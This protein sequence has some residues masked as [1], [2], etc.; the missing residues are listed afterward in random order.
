MSEYNDSMADIVKEFILESHEGLEQVDHDLVQLERHPENHELI[1]RIFRCVHTIKGTCG[2]LG[3]N[4][5]ES[6]THVG[7][8][9]LSQL[10]DRKRVL[11][12]E[13][14]NCLL[15]M[16]DA[17][18]N[19]L[20]EIEA[21]GTEPADT[22][23][24]LIA[25][26]TTLQQAGS[27]PEATA[28][29]LN[30]DIIEAGEEINELLNTQP[31]A[32]AISSM[33]DTPDAAPSQSRSHGIADSSIRVDVALLDRLM[34]LVGEL[35]LSRNQILQH[36]AGSEDPS[37]CSAS[38]RLNM[39]T[40]ELQEG[41]MKT[42]MQPINT[43]W[44]KIPRVVRD[45]A[46]Q[47][48]K[49]IRVEMEGKDT[50]LDKTI[51]EAIKD[52]LTHIIRNSVD[53]GL[54]SPDV[55][56][57]MGKTEE[58]RITLRARHE[59]G[60]VIIEIADDGGGINTKRVREK[61]LK[62]GIITPEQAEKMSERELQYLIFAAGFSTAAKVS[63]VSGR[64]VGMDVVKTNI[65][66]IGGTV[67]IQSETGQGATMKVK[68]PLTLAIVPALLVTCA[69]ERFAIPQ[70]NLLELVRLEGDAARS[71]IETIH[72]SPLYRL[73]GQLL[74]V[75]YLDRQLAIAPH[76]NNGGGDSQ[77][78]TIL[79]IVVLQADERKFCLVVDEIN[80]SQEIV[81]KPLGKLVKDLSVFAGATILGDGKVALI[82]DVTGLAQ[83]ARVVSETRDRLLSDEH[84]SRITAAKDN[85][86][87]LLLFNLNDGSRMAIPLNV[88]ARLEEFQS[89]R[90]ESVGGQYVIQYRGQILPLIFVS[91]VF[92]HSDSVAD[93]AKIGAT[94]MQVV[95]YTNKGVSI[96]L[97]VD[98]I[99]DIVE[100][101][102]DVQ[103]KATRHGATGTA[104]IRERVHELLDVETII[105]LA[106][107]DFGS[108]GA[109]AAIT[110]VDESRDLQNNHLVTT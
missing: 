85:A 17:V 57:A 25:D 73:R 26:L 8:N 96:G 43:I 47:C 24:A 59:S 102:V 35:V 79:N 1:S 28:A 32:A 53:H 54:E 29:A 39:I 36:I 41:V 81:V 37:L 67:D 40:S 68:I 71:S 52:P 109:A 33:Q 15:K 45:L 21:T 77:E 62:V 6:L 4:N 74:P 18:K 90:I 83:Y 14:T 2:F 48:G 103:G 69:R 78:D 55:R 101:V 27:L 106:G 91:D 5:L 23:E 105:T 50:E 22:Y 86:Q 88:V 65:E 11:T 94:T 108:N 31:A 56:V 44:G 87:T 100:E 82:L 13:I 61:A 95:V 104:V 60:Q 97:V 30:S 12:A 107:L 34:T 9:L 70:V 92:G 76:T 49:N 66:K 42:R 93:T 46:Q 63:N 10:R 80:D 72:G 84:D 98:K 51:I 64:G 19:N 110:A 16:V 20:T 89:T 3:F 7:E 38:Q 99:T 58:G 75:V